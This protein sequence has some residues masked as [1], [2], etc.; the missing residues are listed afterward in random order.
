LHSHQ[1]GERWVLSDSRGFNLPAGGSDLRNGSM[2]T[3]AK[4]PS[5]KRSQDFGVIRFLLGGQ[6]E[7]S[8]AH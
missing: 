3:L 5:P 1:K 2:G 8:K 6:I 4:K 7:R